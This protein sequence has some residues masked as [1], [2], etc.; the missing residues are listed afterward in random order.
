MMTAR[1]MVP[2]YRKM[3]CRLRLVD[4]PLHSRALMPKTEA[5]KLRGKNLGRLG[6][7]FSLWF[8]A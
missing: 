7:A 5:K 2:M 4:V 1:E 8:Q 6:L 3:A